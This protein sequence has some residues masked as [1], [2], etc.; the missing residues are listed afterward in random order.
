MKAAHKGPIPRKNAA[1][2]AQA[3][4]GLV[5]VFRTC[6]VRNYIISDAG[7]LGTGTTKNSFNCNVFPGR[8]RGTVAG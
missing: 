2:E 6:A 5:S 3:Y 7:T 8:R 4:Y 1:Y